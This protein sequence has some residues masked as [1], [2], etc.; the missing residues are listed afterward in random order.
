MLS[1]ST[2]INKI[3]IQQLQQ[4]ELEYECD[5][6]P[7]QI[8]GE[9]VYCYDER[10]NSLGIFAGCTDEE[11]TLLFTAL[12][13]NHPLYWDIALEIAKLLPTKGYLVKDRLQLDGWTVDFCYHGFNQMLLAYLGSSK[14]YETRI[15]ELLDMIPED[16]R[17]GLFLACEAL[18]T[19][20]IC[21]KLMEKFTQ[22]IN[23]DS[24]YGKG[25]GEMHY[26]VR[27][28]KLWETT[29]DTKLLKE[30]VRNV[31]KSSRT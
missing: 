12:I 15:I 28:I 11:L 30:F 14:K 18:N 20:L 8:D 10:V 17:D 31:E 3:I 1:S 29:Q 24:D 6:D 21:R 16:Y 22:W 19:P 4:H 2:R 25:T 7:N 27:F 5:V 13:E 9:V 26:L 23:A